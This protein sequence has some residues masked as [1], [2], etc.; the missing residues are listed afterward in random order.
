MDYTKIPNDVVLAKVFEALKERNVTPI[1]VDTKEQAL[2]EI[3]K[4]I[5]ACLFLRAKSCP[6]ATS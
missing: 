1:I 2:E 6:I 4:I 3:K 5:P